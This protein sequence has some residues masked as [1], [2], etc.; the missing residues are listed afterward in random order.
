MKTLKIISNCIIFMILTLLISC[1]KELEGDTTPP[2]LVSVSPA[3]GA[4]EVSIYTTVTAKFSEPVIVSTS[5]FYLT[6][7]ESSISVEAEISIEKNKVTLTPADSLQYGTEYIAHLSDKIS[8]VAGN[9]LKKSHEWS[10]TTT[11]AP[12]LEPPRIVSIS[13]RDGADSVSVDTKVIVEFSEPVIVNASDLYLIRPFMGGSEKVATEISTEGNKC[14]L[15]PVEPLWYNTE[16]WVSIG[17]EIT[18][19]AGNLIRPVDEYCIFTTKVSPW[20]LPRKYFVWSIGANENDEI[21]IG[22]WFK[23]TK[24]I[25]YCFFA[26]FDNQGKLIWLKKYSTPVSPVYDV[27]QGPTITVTDDFIYLGVRVDSEWRIDKYTMNGEKVWSSQPEWYP[28]PV[29]S[30]DSYFR[31]IPAGDGNLY[32]LRDFW[33]KGQIVYKLSSEGQLISQVDCQR[34]RVSTME[35]TPY[36][37]LLLF[38]QYGDD[39]ML[40]QLAY[41]DL[42]WRG[43]ASFPSGTHMRLDGN[44]LFLVGGREASKYELVEDGVNDE[45]SIEYN[46]DTRCEVK[47]TAVDQDGNFYVLVEDRGDELGLSWKWTKISP[48]GEV[49]ATGIVRIDLSQGLI[50]FTVPRIAVIRN[51]VFV[52][53]YDGSEWVFDLET[54]AKVRIR[55]PI[56]MG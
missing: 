51:K 27:L 10:F 14:I 48:I 26:R 22:G 16:Y 56:E 53:V 28:N 9:T 29:V 8:D 52:L 35:S 18:D 50:M 31:I 24:F 23:E 54:G 13:P 47:H 30:E 12:D 6:E 15:T 20:G 25:Y 32:M 2:Q 1:E 46:T 5:S 3:D 40:A 7:A 36:D 42:S 19:L 11:S 45:W 55:G 49:K 37:Y 21:F 38:G 44:N 34:F 33:N 43:T 17:D 39:G 41:S 4:T